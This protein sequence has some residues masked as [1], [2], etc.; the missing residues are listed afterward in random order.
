MGVTG[1]DEGPAASSEEDAWCTSEH[2]GWL[3]APPAPADAP[4]SVSV[5][6]V[7][8]SVAWVGPF[9]GGWSVDADAD[10]DA[11]EEGAEAWFAPATSVT[12][13]FSSSDMMVF[14]TFVISFISEI[15]PICNTCNECHNPD[16]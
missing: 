13:D 5:P 16:S 1:A 6:A 15:S 4:F 14:A 3:V 7:A 8:P 10:V 2:E 9:G 12:S 11:P